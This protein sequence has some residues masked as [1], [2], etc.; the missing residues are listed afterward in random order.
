[1]KRNGGSIGKGYPGLS[2]YLFQ[3]LLLLL[4]PG[5]YRSMAEGRNGETGQTDRFLDGGDE[6][7][8][9][10]IQCWNLNQLPVILQHL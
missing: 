8:I 4:V 7:V 1:M 5:I 10:R 9:Q 2:E 6:G 3:L